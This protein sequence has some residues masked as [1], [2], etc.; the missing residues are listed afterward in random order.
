MT[1]KGS[2]YISSSGF[3]R[4]FCHFFFKCGVIGLGTADEIGACFFLTSPTGPSHL[5]TGTLQIPPLLFFMSHPTGYCDLWL[6]TVLCRARGL[7][8]SSCDLL[9]PLSPPTYQTQSPLWYS[10]LRRERVE[11]MKWLLEEYGH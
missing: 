5:C 1:R 9:V 10:L 4:Y 2:I 6:P 11:F 7:Q 3:S 8:L